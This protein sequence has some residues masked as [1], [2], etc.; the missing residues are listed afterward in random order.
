M[1]EH[2]GNQPTFDATCELFREWPLGLYI[3]RYC[4]PELGHPRQQVIL[5]PELEPLKRLGHPSQGLRILVVVQPVSD[6][7]LVPFLLVHGVEYAARVAS[8][9]QVSLPEADF[10]VAFIFDLLKV[11]ISVC[12]DQNSRKAKRAQIEGYQL[13]VLECCH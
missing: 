7:A 9:G 1:A 12:I 3:D 4:L 8:T 5:L 10:K 6:I 2:D 13:P 11:A